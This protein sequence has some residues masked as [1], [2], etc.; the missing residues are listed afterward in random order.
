MTSWWAGSARTPLSQ[1]LADRVRG[2][3]RPGMVV[4][5]AWTLETSVHISGRLTY[6]LMGVPGRW[7]GPVGV[8]DRSPSIMFLA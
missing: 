1:K 8:G 7:T 3:S 2:S 4:L 5:P 6:F